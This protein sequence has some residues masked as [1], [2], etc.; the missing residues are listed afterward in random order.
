MSE[1]ASYHFINVILVGVAV[2]IVY[3]FA[4]ECSGVLGAV[5]ASVSLAFSPHCFAYA[6][7]N[8]KDIPLMVFYL[9][10]IWAFWKGIHLRRHCWIVVSGMLFGLA[11]SNKVTGVFMPVVGYSWLLISYRDLWWR[12]ASN[13]RLANIS[14]SVVLFPFIGISTLLI[15]WPWMWADP[16]GR[17]IEYFRLYYRGFPIRVFYFGA[18]YLSNSLPWHYHYV[19]LV[20]TTPLP[21]MF[22]AVVGIVVAALN[23]VTL[24]NRAFVLLLIWMGISLVK[25]DLPGINRFDGIRHLM[26]GLPP[27]CMLAGVGAVELYRR[28]ISFMTAGE[29]NRSKIHFH[30]RP[31]ISIFLAVLVVSAC[32][33]NILAMSQ[34]HPYE[35]AYFNELI[36]GTEGAG[37]NLEVEFW[38]SSYKEGMS[39]INQHA[40]GY[41]VVGVPRYNDQL[42]KYYSRP[43][44]RINVIEDLTSDGVPDYLMFITRVAFY[45]SAQ[46]YALKNLTPAYAVIVDGTPLLFVYNMSS[47]LHERPLVSVSSIG[48]WSLYQ[49]TGT[50]ATESREGEAKATAA[51][52]GT[53]D[54]NG[55]LAVGY[56][57]PH[58]FNLERSQFITFWIKASL[59]GGYSFI[60]FDR[61]GNWLL[62]QTYESVLHP[63]VW[64]KINLPIEKPSGRSIGKV[65]LNSV[66]SLV[67]GLFNSDGNVCGQLWVGTIAAAS[68][69]LDSTPDS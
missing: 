27:L 2:F 28:A 39:W 69:V 51:I 48:Q 25:L 66:Q 7:M 67:V 22:L 57:A 50:V 26:E 52:N 35:Y 19:H 33:P 56:D 32:A 68:L 45:T 15:M 44:I 21:I 64:T 16:V 1:T 53:T 63:N 3:R 59:A 60:L 29:S 17:L 20:L 12:G 24:R 30:R 31:A 43:D 18:I 13:P 6:H 4:L 40:K 23:A 49:G 37:K 10:G 47:A 34:L 38:G 55:N 61:H 58:L 65:D 14:K 8:V 54:P 62:W 41:S 46:R 42:V 36:G 5:V 9:A 11:L